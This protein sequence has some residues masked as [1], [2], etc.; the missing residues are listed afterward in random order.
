MKRYGNRSGNSGV[1]AYESGPDWIQ[2]QFVDGHVYEY[3]R[4]SAGAENL[5]T[6]KRLAQSGSGLS[7]FI[8]TA[9][10]SGYSKRVR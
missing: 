7:T 9:V 5:A 1:V 3:T 4:A 2:V 6:M 8:S 10:K